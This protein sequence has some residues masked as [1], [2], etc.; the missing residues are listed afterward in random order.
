MTGLDTP[1]TFSS[2]EL[3]Q[4]NTGRVFDQITEV[5][6][7]LDEVVKNLTEIYGLKNWHFTSRVSEGNYL[8]KNGKMEET[9]FE[10]CCASAWM[11][12]IEF[13]VVQVVTGDNAYSEFFRRYGEGLCCVRENIPGDKWKAEI[14]RYRKQGAVFLQTEKNSFGETIWIDTLETFGGLIAIHCDGEVPAVIPEDARNDRKLVQINITSPDV[15]KTVRQLCNLLEMGPWEIGNLNN[16]SVSE[17]GILVD[18][19]LEEPEFYFK[20][21]ISFYAGLEFEVIQ[22]VSGP[23]VYQKYIDRR[24]IGFHHIKEIIPAEKWQDTMDEYAKK[25]MPLAIKGKIGRSCF[26]YLDS[27]EEF[28]FY[29][30]MGDGQ[31]VNPL[32]KGY[33]AYCYPEP[34]EH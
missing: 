6:D 19:K 25:K 21:G 33:D 32:P 29:L 26:C 11:G 2:Q 18:G 5:T 30:E 1:T 13:R 10:E 27:E 28:G 31:P 20:L 22:P 4:R 15:D 9:Y 34:F 17:P 24:G 16:I 7:R 14:D 3:I 12:G 8:L 23:T